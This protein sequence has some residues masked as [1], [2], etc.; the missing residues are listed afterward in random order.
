M[1]AISTVSLWTLAPWLPLLA[2]SG[3]PDVG[4]DPISGVEPAVS[5][6]PG[7]LPNGTSSTRQAA[8]GLTLFPGGGTS[9]AAEPLSPAL[10]P[11]SISECDPTPSPGAAPGG[12]VQTVCFFGEDELDV[13][14]ATIEQIV[15]VVGNDEWVHIR[16]TLNPDFVDNTY[17]DTAIGWGEREARENEPRPPRGPRAD[18]ADAGPPPPPED[19]PAPPNGEAPPPPPPPGADGPD[20]GPPPPPEEAPPPPPDGAPPVGEPPAPPAAGAADGPRAPREPGGPGGPGGGP[21]RGGH[22][23]RDLL[24]SDH[25]ELQLLDATGAAAMRFKIDYITASDGAASGF[26]SLGV[27]GGEGALLEGDPTWVLAATTSIDRNLNA[28]GL[29]S[30]TESSPETDALYTP[31][32][33]AS[34]WDYRVSY[35]IWVSAAAFGDAGFGSALIENVHASPSKAP[36]DTVDVLPAP[37]PADPAQPN[38]EPAP[39]PAVLEEIR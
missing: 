33:D 26:A 8:L 14:A 19:A 4:I 15:E 13:P 2:C 37:C 9:G 7:T 5:S 1:R 10:G 25:A 22:T 35:E 12:E 29:S 32:P 24:G 11:E 6:E 31:N 34:D 30:F 39:L 18:G 17:G 16:L 23:F 28:C 20:A 3:Q 38:V 21:G 27:D 36:G